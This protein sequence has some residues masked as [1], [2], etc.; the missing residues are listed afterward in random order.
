MSE[1]MYLLDPAVIQDL[2]EKS[3]DP[4][5]LLSFD[6]PQGYVFRG[7]VIC[8][9]IDAAG[10]PLVFLNPVFQNS[11]GDPANPGDQDLV[12]QTN[13][14]KACPYPPGYPSGA[15]APQVNP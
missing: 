9:S 7:F 13:A 15:G 11:A 3:K 14:A 2:A 10:Q 8:P 6:L 1:S 4:K 12:I 5:Q